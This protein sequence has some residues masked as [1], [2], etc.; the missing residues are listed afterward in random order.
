MRRAVDLLVAVGCLVIF[1]PLIVLI[2][3]LIRLDSPGAIL[4]SPRMIG[5]RGKVF[6]L[7]RFRTMSRQ[8][9]D[10]DPEQ[11]LTRIGW[12]I[13][14]YSLDH[15]P[16]LVNLL[17]GDLTLVGPRPME[18]G[19]VNMQDPVWQQY[20][21][22]WPGLFNYAVL[23]LGRLWTPIRSTTPTLNQELEL[24][25]LQT[26]SWLSDLK[27]FINSIR[28]FVISGGNIKARGK[29]DIALKN[30]IDNGL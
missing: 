20:F 11:R 3:A 8:P 5:H 2:A 27:L 1:A 16:M 9:A 15:L 29:P 17:R 7:F 28:V 6:S 24:E 13:R 10:P 30:K 19:V 25:Y 12:F 21:A 18:T 26:R 4:Y 23:K 22:V 14:E